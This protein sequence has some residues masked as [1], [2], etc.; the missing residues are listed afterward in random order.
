MKKLLII[1]LVAL[2]GLSVPAAQAHSTR[3]MVG[4]GVAGVSGAA[5]LNNAYQ[6]YANAKLRTQ[7]EY[8]KTALLTI[9]AVLGGYAGY[10][11]TEQPAGSNAVSPTDPVTPPAVGDD[12]GG[13][14]KDSLD[15]PGTET[16]GKGGKG[17]TKPG[18]EDKPKPKKPT[19]P[20]PPPRVP[21]DE[22][23]ALSVD[24]DASEEEAEEVID[25]PK[26]KKK[27]KPTEITVSDASDT[28]EDEDDED[29]ES[30]EDAGEIEG[31]IK[32]IEAA[33]KTF[34]TSLKKFEKLRT[35]DQ[36]AINAAAQYLMSEAQQVIAETDSLEITIKGKKMSIGTLKGN[37]IPVLAKHFGVDG[38][39]LAGIQGRIS[40]A[41]VAASNALQ[42][43]MFPI[44]KQRGVQVTMSGGDF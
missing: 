19:G 30:D 11:D 17:L 41:Q 31:V 2:V 34:R 27:G 40:K 1:A 6:M 22:D 13:K 20:T 42:K 10:S 5:A 43:E 24:T 36:D 4:Y 9:I 25:A 44:L 12:K 32:K 21:V 29:D 3:K 39:V 7:K 18:K 38:M 16:G 33:K 14:P 8:T 35:D 37:P 15:K 28:E 23:D 26:P